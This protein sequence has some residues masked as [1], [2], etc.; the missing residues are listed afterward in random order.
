MYENTKQ[1]S[2]DELGVFPDFPDQEI[3]GYAN[4][5]CED[6]E[7]RKSEVFTDYSEQFFRKTWNIKVLDVK[8][9]YRYF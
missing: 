6:D 2:A 8:R 3:E 5:L 7:Q 4:Q 1:G 9:P